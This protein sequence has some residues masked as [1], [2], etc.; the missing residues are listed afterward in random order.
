M[1]WSGGKYNDDPFKV[2][3]HTTEGSTA[4]SAFDK[5]NQDHKI[6][7][8]T[9]DATHIYQHLDTSVAA[10][11]LKHPGNVQTNKSS[12]IQYE[13]V[14]FAGRDKDRDALKNAGRLC[15]WIEETHDVPKQWPS[16]Y[17]DPPKDGNDPGHHN[18][19]VPNWNTK[20]GHYGHC[21]VPDNIHW[22]PA[23]TKDEVEFLMSVTESDFAVAALE[24]HEFAE[25]VMPNA[26]VLLDKALVETAEP[27]DSA[28]QASEAFDKAMDKI[29]E[30]VAA[31][32]TKF[33]G[34]FPGGINY[35]EFSVA[36]TTGVKIV[37]SSQPSPKPPGGVAESSVPGPRSTALELHT[38]LDE[39]AAAQVFAAAVPYPEWAL[40]RDLQTAKANYWTSIGEACRESQLDLSVVLAIGS[41]ESQWGLILRPVGPTGTGDWTPRDPA[42]WGHSMP[43]D[44]KGWGRG[45][46]Q[47]DWYSHDFAKTGEWYDADKNIKYGCNLLRQNIDRFVGQ[48]IDPPTALR[49]AV[50]AYNGQ[51]GP[52]SPY[53]EDVMKRADWFAKNP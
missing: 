25:A 3:H 21:H 49:Y 9:V 53:C 7:H 2:V 43:T 19:S 14:G 44:G 12:A 15:R 5:Y 24:D 38:M 28:T 6:P 30:L 27:V 48:G 35:F 8:F 23:F 11:A 4:Q 34:F 26:G 22:D 10:R 39:V 20:G 36:P 13:L 32:D 41:K 31:G 52:H 50:S 17:P 47:I 37:I 46:M 40:K 1:P 16:G 45:L 29:K 18:R 42:K 33:G 51:H